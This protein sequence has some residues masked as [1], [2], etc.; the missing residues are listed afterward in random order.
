MK[1][2]VETDI[3]RD[4]DDFFALCYLIDAG[5]D[6]KAVTISPGD[7]DQVAVTKFLLNYCGLNIPVGVGKIRNK[8]S[9]GGVHLEILDMFNA[10]KTATPDGMGADIIQSVFLAHPDCELFICG[11]LNSVGGFLR[12]NPNVKINKATMQGGYVSYEDLEKNGVFPTRKIEK[13]ISNSTVPTFNLNGDV[14]SGELFLAADIAD[15]R[16]VSKNVCHTIVYDAEI[17]K[18]IMGVQ[19]KTKAGSLFRLGM[20]KYLDRHHEGKKFHDPSAAVCHLHPDIA[21]W[22]R[23]DLYRRSGGYGTNINADGRSRMIG[24]LDY[25]KM[26]DLIANG[27]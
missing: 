19:P 27:K 3:G 16:F 7:P 23:G 21:T 13:F 1:L 8:S 4:P 15:R 6:I 17:H 5:V 12:N 18:R 9:V 25:D 24:A 22:V 26:W 10:P 11:P 2:I 14:K 20:G